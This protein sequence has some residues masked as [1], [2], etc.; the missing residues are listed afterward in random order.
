MGIAERLNIR[1]LLGLAYHT[2]LL[3]GRD[4]WDA[5]P[6]LTRAQR[7]RLLSGHYALTALWEA[8][9]GA[10]PPLAH[11]PRCQAQARCA[12][13]WASLWARA[14]EIGAQV[15]PLSHADV[16]GKLMLAQSFLRGLVTQVRTSTCAACAAFAH[17]NSRT[18]RRRR[19]SCRFARRTHLRG[20][21][22]A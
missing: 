8:L 9:P 14:L 2:M 16:P 21:K 19:S 13:A 3:R 5:D 6:H 17:G 7:V 11:G 15:V 18:S 1:P 12:K 22:L 10:P 4:A 20:P